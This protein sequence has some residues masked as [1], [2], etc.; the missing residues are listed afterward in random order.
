MPSTQHSALS[1][2]GFEHQI[3]IFNQMIDGTNNASHF[4]IFKWTVH[5]EAFF[6]N[7]QRF[8]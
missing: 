1:V 6:K 5:L 8:F 4:K 3:N 2:E 7:K